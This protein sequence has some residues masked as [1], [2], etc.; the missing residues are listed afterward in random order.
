LLASRTYD[1]PGGGV[2]TVTAGP[3]TSW[4]RYRMVIAALDTS[5]MLAGAGI[6]AILRVSFGQTT[7]QAR[8]PYASVV[9]LLVFAWLGVIALGRGYDRRFLG[10]GSEEYRRVLSSA[11][12]LLSVVAI[13]A[14][15]LDMDVAR[16]FVALTIPLGATLTLAERFLVR[17]WLHNQRAR[18]RFLRQTLLVGAEPKVRDLA[19]IVRRLPYAG[20][21]V[22]AACVPGHPGGALDIDGEELPV[23]GGTDNLLGLVRSSGAEALLVADRSSLDVDSLRQLAWGLEGTGISLLVAPEVTDIAGPLTEVRPMSSLPVLAVDEPELGGAR[24][25]VKEAFDR[26]FAALCLLLLAPALVV[27]GIAIRL[28]SPGPALFRQVRVGLRGRRFVLWKF[29][30]MTADAEE[31]RATL[32]DRNEHD[33]VLFKI[34]DDPRVTRFGR[35]LR[36]WS[37]DEIPQLWNVVRGE[38]SI[39][40]P[41]PPLPAE[42]ESYTDRVRRRL[43]VKPGMT[44]LW[45]ISGRAGLPWE[46]SVRLDLHYVENWSPSLDMAILAK[47]VS[48][49]VRGHGA[50]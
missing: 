12:R 15:V 45:Q 28:T 48:A 9:L 3:S 27:V 25:V 41:R 4:R 22:W 30:T 24:Y 16:I 44:G 38:M 10:S 40:G 17:R 18:G 39:V 50:Y 43:L 5:A 23:L 21:Q 32:L 33:G 20:L 49:V 37:I 11:A 46:E 31:R 13:V 8:V 47:T 2:Q 14:L 7:P 35:R 34:R 1:L 19:R 36:R 42:V 29:R 6:A 26:T